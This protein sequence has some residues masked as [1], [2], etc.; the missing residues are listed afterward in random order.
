MKR[1]RL[2]QH[3]LSRKIKTWHPFTLDIRMTCTEAG[4]ADI[5]WSNISVPVADGLE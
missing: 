5:A 1:M 2:I 3:T 4:N